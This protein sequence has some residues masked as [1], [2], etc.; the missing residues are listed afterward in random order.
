MKGVKRLTPST[1]ETGDYII[2]V[3]DDYVFGG[4][5]LSGGRAEEPLGS[6]TQDEIAKLT[7]QDEGVADFSVNAL[8]T[9]RSLSSGARNMKVL[10]R[11]KYQF[12]VGIK[13]KPNAQERN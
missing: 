5:D 2:V 6:M 10:H 8:A 4:S 9:F 13:V 3:E 12:D 1:Y 7:M 11:R